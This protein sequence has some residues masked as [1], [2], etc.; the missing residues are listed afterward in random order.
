MVVVKRLDRSDA[1][2]AA[3]WDAFVLGCAQASFFHRA[4]WQ[5][6]IEDVFRHDTPLYE[7][8]NNL[9]TG[10]SEGR[11]RI[12]DVGAPV[13]QNV[14]LQAADVPPTYSEVPTAVRMTLG[15]Y[16]EIYSSS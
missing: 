15:M 16:P 14:L 5:G 3:R 10:N 13:H 12:N 11:L 7:A 2:Q 9:T 1:A 6:V 8:L 4:T